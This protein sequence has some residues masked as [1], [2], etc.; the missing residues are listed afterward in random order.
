MSKERITRFQIAYDE[1][2]KVCTAICGTDQIRDILVGC[3]KELCPVQY[4]AAKVTRAD[5]RNEDG[6][7]FEDCTVIKIN[8][9]WPVIEPLYDAVLRAMRKGIGDSISHSDN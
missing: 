3:F 2:Q 4:M 7:L 1:D 5:T 9:E 8:V 6:D